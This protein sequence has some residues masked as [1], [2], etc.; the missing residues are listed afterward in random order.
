M[1][2]PPT[3]ASAEAVRMN[4]FTGLTHRIISSTARGS[5]AGSSRSRRSSA[6]CR[7]SA[8]RPPAMVELVV[9]CPAVAMRT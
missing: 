3:S 9:S 6:G 2:T 1:R 7:M 8:S 4:S 5:R